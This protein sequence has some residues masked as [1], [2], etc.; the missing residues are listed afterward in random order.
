MCVFNICILVTLLCA[1]NSQISNV[2]PHN[3]F[4]NIEICTMLSF[5]MRNMFTILSPYYNTKT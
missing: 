3:S 5:N 2:R 4:C 1:V